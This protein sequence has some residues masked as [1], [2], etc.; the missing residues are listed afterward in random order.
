MSISVNYHILII[1]DIT[2]SSYVLI[3]KLLQHVY[4]MWNKLPYQIYY[5]RKI[6][7]FVWFRTLVLTQ[8]FLIKYTFWLHFWSICANRIWRVN[9]KHWNPCNGWVMCVNYSKMFYMRITSL[10]VKYWM[11]CDCDSHTEE[12]EMVGDN[13]FTYHLHTRAGSV[14]WFVSNIDKGKR[15][16][17]WMDGNV[18]VLHYL[19]DDT[20][21]NPYIKD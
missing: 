11:F 17:V 16:N 5:I 8:N 15:Y 3:D 21:V 18:S 12:Q 14:L 1:Q 20:M 9:V 4:I 10:L 13:M 7:L 2:T 6:C 19:K